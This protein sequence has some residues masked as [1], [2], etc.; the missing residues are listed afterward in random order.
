MNTHILMC[1]AGLAITVMSHAQDLAMGCTLR[2]FYAEQELVLTEGELTQVFVPCQSGILEFINIDAQSANDKTF[3]LRLRL[4]EVVDGVETLV[5]QQQGMTPAKDLDRKTVFSLSE[6]VEVDAEK[7]YHL[8]IEVPKDQETRF[9]Y[10]SSDAYKEGHLTVNHAR[11]GGDLAFEAGVNP[12]RFYAMQ[13]DGE[14]LQT[15]HWTVDVHPDEYNLAIAQT[16]FDGSEIM[17]G[18]SYS[19]TFFNEGEACLEEIWFHG[20]F[21]HVEN[22]IPV[23]LFDRALDTYVGYGILEEHASE[24]NTLVARFCDIVLK[25][26]TPY[27]FFVDCGDRQQINLRIVTQPEYFIGEFKQMEEAR[28]ANLSFIAFLD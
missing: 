6:Q 17:Y 11:L 1:I 22:Q 23:Y 2:Q 9:R 14:I 28:E 21:I 10:S 15:H 3:G 4:F 27:E 7:I 13:N 26:N 24:Q 19:Q 20:E 16:K 5:H 18:S 8:K 25:E 12:H